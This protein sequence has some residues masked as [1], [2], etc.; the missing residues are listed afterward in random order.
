MKK[1][2]LVYNFRSGNKNNNGK[3]TY[4]S[5]YLKKGDIVVDE[6]LFDE[7]DKKV[8]SKLENRLFE[9]SYD[10]IVVYGGDGTINSVV[11]VKLKN[12]LCIP[13][14]LIPG[15][16]CND[17]AGDIGIK[18][19]LMKCLDIIIAG[20]IRFVDVGLINEERY[21]VGTCS[22]GDFVSVS[23]NTKRPVKR[24]VGKVAYYFMALIKAPKLKRFDLRISA[25]DQLLI[26][27]K[28]IIFIIMNGHQ[29]AGFKIIRNVKSMNDGTMDG[30]VI[31]DC[32][33]FL[34][35]VLFLKAV[36]GL[37]KDDKRLTTFKFSECRVEIMNKVEIEIDGEKYDKSELNIKIIPN[38]LNV[39]VP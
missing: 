19:N 5:E 30:F 12:N 4:I 13:I 29:A 21:F 23:Y 28:A 8:K 20:K 10:L 15:G 9:T 17:F 33:L 16:T 32:S 27:G 26:N 24:L 25:Q 36:F 11:N 22:G 14:G 2:L 39:Y 35:P 38:L 37:L 18:N 3:Y 1:A 7:D 31:R 34:L 6:F